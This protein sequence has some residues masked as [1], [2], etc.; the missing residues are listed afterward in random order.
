ML[1]DVEGSVVLVA[2]GTYSGV[3]GDVEGCDEPPDP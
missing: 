2:F 3:S 1:E